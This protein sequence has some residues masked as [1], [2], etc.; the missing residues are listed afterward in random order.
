MVLQQG[1]THIARI[2]KNREVHQTSVNHKDTQLL[3]V[4]KRSTNVRN[5]QVHFHEGGHTSIRNSVVNR[6][7]HH[8]VEIFSPVIIQCI[9]VKQ[10]VN[11]AIYIFQP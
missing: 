11:R 8:T 2:T 6:R 9:T 7:T 1:D 5:E 10:R 4:T 3:N